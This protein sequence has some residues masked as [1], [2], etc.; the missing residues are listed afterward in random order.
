LKRSQDKIKDLVEARVFTGVQNFA[1][2]PRRALSSYLF[3]DATSDLFARWL[4]TLADLPP[5]RGAARALAG[6]RGVGKS[7]MLVAFSAIVANQELR[8]TVADAHVATSAERL[9]TRKYKVARVQRGT[10][11]T[12]QEEIAAA[13]DG[14]FEAWKAEPE[15]MLAYSADMAGSGLV[16]IIDTAF[17]REARVDRDDGPLL[18][19]LVEV[20]Q[21]QSIFIALALDDD[22]AGADGANVA[23]SGSFQIDY[24]D[25]EHLYRITDVHLFQK[26]EQSRAALHEMYMTLRKLVPGFNWS[27]PRF[28]SVYPMHPLIA[29]VAAAIR[30]YIPAFAFLPF[31]SA[32]GAL[33]ANRPALSLVVL[34]EMFDRTETDLRRAEDLK[35]AF[36]AYDY[37]EKKAISQIPVMQR[38]QARLVL[39]GLFILSLDGR[40]ATA[41]ELGAAMLLYDEQHPEAAIERIENMLA[42]FSSLA[43]DDSLAKNLEQGESRYRFSIDASA[44]FNTALAAAAQQVAKDGKPLGDL[45]QTLGRARFEDWPFTST[46]P[47]EQATSRSTDFGILWRGTARP[48]RIVWQHKHAPVQPDSVDMSRYDWEVV[49]LAPTGA[50]KTSA[51]DE[52]SSNQEESNEPR[53]PHASTFAIWK[54]AELTPEETESLRRLIALRADTE[55]LAKFNETA[56]AAERIH[57][58]LVERI[59]TRIYMDDGVLILN[60]H[61]LEFTDEG[62]A[63]NTLSEALSYMLAPALDEAYPQHPVFNETPGESRVAALVAGLFGGANQWDEGVQ[64]LARLF[65]APLGLVSTTTSSAGDKSLYALETGDQILKNPAVREVLALSDEADGSTVSLDEVYGRLRGR[66][67][68]FQRETQQLILASLV[69]GRRIELVTSGGDRIGSRTLGHGVNWEE[70]AGIA[71]VA[72]LSLGAQELTEWAALLTGSQIP[73]SIAEPERRETVRQALAEWLDTWRADNPLARFDVLLDEGLTTRVWNLAASVRKSFGVAAGA[74]EDALTETVSLEEGLQR[75]ADAFNL[76]PEQFARARQQLAQLGSFITE[77]PRREERRAYLVLADLTGVDEIESA[78]RELL[79]IANDVHNLLDTESVNRFD[80]LWREFHTRYME[81]YAQ[82]HDQVLREPVHRRRAEELT[83]TDDW[84]EFELLSEIKILNRRYWEEAN[85]LLESARRA[86]CELPVRQQLE[87]RPLCACRFRLM[88]ASA[89]SQ[90]PQ[91]LADTV[92]RGREAYRRT[93]LLMNAPLAIALD[94]LAR[95][96]E[97]LDTARARSL[98]GA[99]AQNTA[100]AHFSAA[101]IDLIKEALG[102]MAT[103]PPVRLRLPGSDYGLLTRDELRARLN[104]WLDDLPSEPAL[105]EVI[106][107]ENGDGG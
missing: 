32:A 60:Q 89:L 15:R 73:G 37:L 91:E 81:H 78:R 105:V 85:Q 104:Q 24:L 55:L 29:D 56:R 103:P 86:R 106:D 68:G 59:W 6:P 94:A 57:T 16:L 66:P 2:D 39:K 79:T 45:L 84:Q 44:G 88:S 22:I 69:A 19:Q 43:P 40:G 7:H 3:T 11:P 64:E 71:R 5:N 35:D 67:F 23:L 65:A 9:L 30:L 36:K 12:L 74:I 21:N 92:A 77:L 4:D 107:L 87:S 1:D 70:V 83:R 50:K 33:A 41:R 20:A 48:G 102:R 63:A 75:V 99:F 49:M 96:E 28:A 62:R 31:A 10:Y 52:A 101:D 34:D 27:E 13:L 76:S 93:L 61:S 8:S 17:E 82:A 100:P 95:K 58:A 26:N 47:I 25:P 53:A 38:L 98:S 90:L 51:D 14:D 18:S 42:S 54:P 80:M 97:T 72:T 46:E